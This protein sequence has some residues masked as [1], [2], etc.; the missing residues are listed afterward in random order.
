MTTQCNTDFGHRLRII[1]NDFVFEH[2]EC[3]YFPLNGDWK[4]KQASAKETTRY[5]HAEVA[6]MKA[7]FPYFMKEYIAI[8]PEVSGQLH[9]SHKTYLKTH[10]GLDL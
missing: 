3:F 4:Q 2:Q 9:E 8:P 7:R 1:P 10:F 5:Y 6:C